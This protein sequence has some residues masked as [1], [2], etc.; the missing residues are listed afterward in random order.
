MEKRKIKNI[1]NKIILNQKFLHPNTLEFGKENEIIGSY[2]TKYYLS[3]NKE[4]KFDKDIVLLNK[5]YNKNALKKFMLLPSV[6]ISSDNLL[7]INNI[8][9]FDDLFSKVKEF[10]N[11]KKEY[12][13]INRIINSWIKSNFDDLK[14][15][16]T[17]LVNLYIYLF[18]HFYSKLLYDNDDNNNKKI[19]HIIDKWFKE[20]KMDNFN[21]N[22]GDSI[23]KYLDKS[24][25][26]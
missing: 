18:K 12:S 1:A 3:L 14:K 8:I 23:K 25:Y 19:I 17:I 20:K 16:N 24:N 22:L 15:K 2:P 7:I 21:L 10:I 5:D 11:D 26:E 13:F 4:L 9:T 6:V